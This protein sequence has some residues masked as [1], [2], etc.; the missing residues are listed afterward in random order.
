[1]ENEIL[2]AIRERRSL[3]RFKSEQIEDETL[4]AVLE[5]G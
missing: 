2:K 1:M 3:R 4:K 5:A